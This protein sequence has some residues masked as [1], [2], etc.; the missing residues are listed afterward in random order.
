[1]RRLT[2]GEAQDLPS[3]VRFIEG[4]LQ[5]LSRL[6]DSRF[7]KVPVLSSDPATPEDGMIWI[8]SDTGQLCWRVSNTTKRITGT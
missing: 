7:G 4:S 6:V 8:R 1:M 2:Q 5:E 3:L